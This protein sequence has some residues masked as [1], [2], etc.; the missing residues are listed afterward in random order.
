LKQNTSDANDELVAQLEKK[1]KALMQFL[2]TERLKSLHLDH[3][4]AK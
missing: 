1:V 2:E 3:V 4:I